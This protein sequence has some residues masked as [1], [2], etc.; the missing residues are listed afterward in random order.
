MKELGTI[1]STAEFIEYIQNYYKISK[2]KKHLF[3]RGHS[4][5][6]FK[7]LPSVFRP[8]SK[9]NEKEILLDFKQYAPDFN[10]S[11][12]FIR[13]IDKVLCDMQHNGL[14]TRLLDWTVSPL[15][16]LYFAVSSN[17]DKNGKIWIFNPWKYNNSIV[18][19]KQHTQIHDI[20]VIA[21]S[22]LAIGEDE[23]I[24]N[25]IKDYYH[26]SKSFNFEDPLAFVA[27]FTNKR[28]IFQRGTFLIFGKNKQAF[29]ENDKSKDFLDYFIIPHRCKKKIFQELNNLYINAYTIY[30]DFKGMQETIK[31]YGS[32]FNRIQLK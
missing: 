6:D 20:H 8:R 7:L 3:F 10:F 27:Q 23:F 22:L 26:F 11:Y 12:D 15:T 18:N 1:T 25:F 13:D 16:A 4:D 19:Y 5:T 2:A 17:L 32:L 31:E 9:Y 29:E 24:N 14:P 30:P 21:R 28:K